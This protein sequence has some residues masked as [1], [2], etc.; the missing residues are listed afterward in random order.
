M[1]LLLA[2]WASA[3]RLVPGLVLLPL[4]VAY[5]S[6]GPYSDEWP[7]VLILPAFMLS[8]SL[9]TVSL[10]VAIWAWCRHRVG[11]VVCTLAIWG[12][13]HTG[14]IA[15]QDAILF[16]AS[17]AVLASCHPFSGVATVTLWISGIRASNPDVLAWTLVASADYATAAGLLFVVALLSCIPSIGSLRKPIPNSLYTVH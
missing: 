5:S 16:D 15:M 17:G 12:C 7:A 4:M 8:I 3:A 2:K 1:R 9:A 11:A 6:S 14:W 10:G 13:T